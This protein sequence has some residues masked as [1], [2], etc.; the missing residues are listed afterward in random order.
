M[1]WLKIQVAII[2]FVMSF[3]SY[4]QLWQ[5]SRDKDI[6]AEQDHQSY[7]QGKQ[8]D[9]LRKQKQAIE[10]LQSQL[11]DHESKIEELETRIEDLE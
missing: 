5:T 8:E 11:D 7:V 4:G 6:Q 9:L 2:M 3:E 10:D 1:Y